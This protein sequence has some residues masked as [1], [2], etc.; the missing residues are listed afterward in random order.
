METVRFRIKKNSLLFFSLLT[1][2][3]S[4]DSVQAG[5]N[6]YDIGTFYIPE[7]VENEN[8]GRFIDL[9]KEIEKRTGRNFT[10]KLLPTKRAIVDFHENRIIGV[11]P[12]V[13]PFFKTEVVKSDV[14]H[15]KREVIFTRKNDSFSNIKELEGKRVGLTLGYSYTD[16]LLSN[17]LI[18]F[19]NAPSDVL[20]M[21]KLSAGRTDA[22][23]CEETSGLKA[24]K[25]SEVEN[26]TYDPAV[27]IYTQKSYF[28]FQPT[29][30]GKLLAEEF[31]AAIKEMKTD[32]TLKK[33]L[34]V[35]DEWIKN[36][37]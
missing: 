2:I 14:F 12:G 33:I 13:D 1:V 30:T 31:S 17:P 29:E 15:L 37:P 26:V 9:L 35:T 3:G 7:F 23:V 10:I 36:L 5:E 8:D 34:G 19:D 16:K 4:G 27:S 25:L 24:M 21:K 6:V 11:F 28:V 18:K 20:N 32:G 22:F